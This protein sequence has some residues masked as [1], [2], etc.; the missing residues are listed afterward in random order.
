MFHWTGCINL[1]FF[2]M[3]Y[4]GYSAAGLVFH[5][6]LN[7]VWLNLGKI[8]AIQILRVSVKLSTH[9]QWCYKYEKWQHGNNFDL[10]KFYILDDYARNQVTSLL[11]H[12]P[13]HT[14]LLPNARS[15]SLARGYM[16]LTFPQYF[17][18]VNSEWH[19]VSLCHSS[20]WDQKN[21]WHN[22]R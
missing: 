13:S 21:Y 9:I 19:W 16:V 17:M 12:V 7:D 1:F 3:Q 11:R 20:E 5:N 8:L 15:S 2:V 14:S 22:N 4:L 10:Y 6:V 18:T